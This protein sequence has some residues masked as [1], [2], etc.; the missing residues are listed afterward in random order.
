M[1]ADNKPQDAPPCIAALRIAFEGTFDKSEIPDTSDRV[2]INNVRRA[3]AGIQAV[4]KILYANEVERD[5][6]GP[7]GDVLDIKTTYGLFDAL[8][9]LSHGGNTDAFDLGQSLCI[10]AK[11]EGSK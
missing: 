3:F 5:S 9:Y 2:R 1:T 10:Q 7:D 8:V 4:A 6:Q 11:G